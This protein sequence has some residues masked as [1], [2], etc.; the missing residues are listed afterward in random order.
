VITQAGDFDTK[1]DIR[2]E[3]GIPSLANAKL[4]GTGALAVT[5]LR[6]DRFEAA[7]SGTAG[8]RRAAPPRAWMRR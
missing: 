3:V 7:V 8:S 1:R 2:V 4:S 5:G 6:A